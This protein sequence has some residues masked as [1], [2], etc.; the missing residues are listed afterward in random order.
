M[1]KWLATLL[2]TVAMPAVAG[3]PPGAS[4]YWQLSGKINT[5]ETAKV[6]DIDGQGNTA[7][8]IAQLKA[9]GHIVVCY[10][11]A[12]GW[13]SYR[14]DASQFPQSVIGNK[15]GGWPERYV[16]IR[17]PVVRAIETARMKSFQAKKCDGVEPDVMDT[18]QNKSGFPITQADETDYALFLAS[19]AHSLNLLVALKNVPELVPATVNSFDFSIAEQAFSQNYYKQLEPFIAQ[20]KAVLGA[21]YQAAINPAWCSEAKAQ[22]MTL[23]FYNLDLNGKRYLPCP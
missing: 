11:D 5:A 6:Y 13:E 1:V 12:G 15:M 8:L 20:G 10:F 21:E 17:S 19:T 9:A 7:A 14:P 18:W 4:W 23:A 2:L 22:Q 3:I 16:D